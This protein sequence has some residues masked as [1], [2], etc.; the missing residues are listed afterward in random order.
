MASSTCF[1][2][3]KQIEDFVGD[4]L[5]T[6]LH[7]NT[8]KRDSSLKTNSFTTGVERNDLADFLTRRKQEDCSCSRLYSIDIKHQKSFRQ[9][10]RIQAQFSCFLLVRK[11]AKSFIST[12]VV[13]EP[14]FKEVSCLFV[15]KYH[16]VIRLSPTKSSICFV[17]VKPV[18]EATK[19]YVIIPF[20][21]VFYP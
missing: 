7:L 20:Y 4:N 11:S 16:A 6:T 19:N 2:A 9:T 10:V 13:N 5:I 15:F 21:T 1:T 14:L 8:K 12:P 17:A 18:D 3:T